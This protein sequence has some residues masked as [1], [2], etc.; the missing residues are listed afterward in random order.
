MGFPGRKCTERILSAS[1]PREFRASF[2]ARR[3]ASAS[4][5]RLLTRPCI[6]FWSMAEAPSFEAEAQKSNWAPRCDSARAPECPAA[7]SRRALLRRNACGH[8]AGRKAHARRHPDPVVG[9]DAI[10]E[11]DLA[12]HDVD[13]HALPGRPHLVH[14]P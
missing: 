1:I 2:K 6:T 8:I 7:R 11:G 13:G 14:Q 9:I 5:S 12:L 4:T 3:F 10:E